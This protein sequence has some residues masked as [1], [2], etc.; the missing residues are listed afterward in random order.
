MTVTVTPEAEPVPAAWRADPPLTAHMKP[1]DT[2]R[3][4]DKKMGERYLHC[5]SE[6]RFVITRR[7]ERPAGKVG[8]DDVAL[9]HALWNELHRGALLLET[10]EERIAL[11]A[12]IEERVPSRCGCLGHWRNW[13][14][15][16]PFDYGSREV[17]FAGTVEAHSAV[18]VR[19]K[20]PILTVAEALAIYA[21]R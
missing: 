20:K 16:N 5:V 8:R 11:V 18:S 12:S 9:Y 6:G 7:N 13:V 14:K 17:F 15:A 10:A 21:G 1:G 3:L 4:V 2:G 19:L